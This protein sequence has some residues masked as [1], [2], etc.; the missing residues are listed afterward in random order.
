[1]VYDEQNDGVISSGKDGVVIAWT[2]EGKMKQTIVLPKHYACAMDLNPKHRVVYM[3]GVAKDP[4]APPAIIAYALTDK[5]A[6][7]PRGSILEKPN[8]LFSCVKALTQDAG[9]TFVMGESSK[10]DGKHS[11]MLYD[12]SS[13]SLD[14]LRPL[15]VWDEHADLITSLA[16]Y[17]NGDGIF[18]S[19]SRDCTVKAWDRRQ[20]QSIGTFGAVNAAGK[21]RTHE[22]MITCLDA[23]DHMLLSGSLDKLVCAWDLRMLSGP[24]MAQPLRRIAVDTSAILKVAGC[25]STPFLAASTLEGLHLVDLDTGAHT[26][27]HAFTDGRKQG[28]Y[29]DLR[30]NPARDTLFAAGDEGRVDL[31]STIVHGP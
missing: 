27:A 24:G 29:H 10:A 21:P 30:W 26:L 22:M 4:S 6:W 3:C 13:S 7:M 28:R 5:G 23:Y 8:R 20:P 12:A 15:S 9:D 2:R 18:F 14:K 1:M 19:G 17:P 11:V 16:S 25:A 31:Y